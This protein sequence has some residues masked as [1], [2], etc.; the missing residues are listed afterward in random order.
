[1]PRPLTIRDLRLHWADAER[2][3]RLEGELVVTRDGQ[4]VAR[5]T[6]YAAPP[7]AARR[8]S[9][10]THGRWLAR[11]WRIAPRGPSTDEWLARDRAG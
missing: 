9:P 2:R 6:A 7:K 11:F 3:L 10:I 1:M 5:L 8:W 4:P